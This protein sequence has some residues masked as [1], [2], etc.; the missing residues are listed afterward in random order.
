MKR[1]LSVAALALFAHTAQAQTY[2]LP[3]RCSG[4]FR[5]DHVTVSNLS[6][7]EAIQFT[8]QTGKYT[9]YLVFA[10][11]AVAGD[12]FQVNAVGKDGAMINTVGKCSISSKTC[13]TSAGE[14]V[15]FHTKGRAK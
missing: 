10:G 1:I 9:H 15:V 7:T 8:R 6:G 11:P 5:C 12:S 2:S 3:G 13:T 4:S 14:N